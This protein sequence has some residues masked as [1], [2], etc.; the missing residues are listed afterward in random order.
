MPPRAP[1]PSPSPAVAHSSAWALLVGTSR[2]APPHFGLAFPPLLRP[3][4]FSL[5]FL[6]A[7]CGG[8]F[9][10]QQPPPASPPSPSIAVQVGAQFEASSLP[11]RPALEGVGFSISGFFS[12]YHAGVVHGLSAWKIASLPKPLLTHAPLS[13]RRRALSARAPSL[14]ALLEGHTARW[15]EAIIFISFTTTHINW[16]I[17]V[18]GALHCSGVAPSAYVKAVKFSAAYCTSANNSCG[19]PGNGS[20]LQTHSFDGLLPNNTWAACNDVLYVQMATKNL[21]STTDNT[22]PCSTTIYAPKGGLVVSTFS[23]RDDLIGALVCAGYQPSQNPKCTCSYHGYDVIDA[24]CAY[25]RYS[26]NR[27]PWRRT[28]LIIILL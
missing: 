8:A 3:L 24:Q 19:F 25:L 26:S 21:D 23:S 16:T 2:V 5:L 14:Q 1:A 7:T 9:A 4:L 13:Q 6:Q 28:S 22:P 27:A 11:P 12:V 17:F 18:V 20:A 15:A 10:R